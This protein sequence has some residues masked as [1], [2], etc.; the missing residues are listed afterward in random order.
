MS[1]MVVVRV[2]AGPLHIATPTTGG[3]ETNCGRTLTGPTLVPF[4][5]GRPAMNVW[6]VWRHC[7]RCEHLD[8]MWRR[9]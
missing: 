7:D 5:A 4:K 6:K 8:R 9:A 3:Y 1:R 2:G